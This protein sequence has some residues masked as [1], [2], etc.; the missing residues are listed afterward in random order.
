MKLLSV[1]AALVAITMAV[2][3][4]RA[5]DAAP[6]PTAVE[7]IKR[8]QL[9]RIEFPT[10]KYA[11]MIYMV[12]IAPG[13]V[14]PRHTHPGVEMTYVQDGEG[15]LLIEGQPEIVLKPGSSFTVPPVTPHS[16]KNTG[17]AAL[18]VVVTYVVE[19]DKPLATAAPLQ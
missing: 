9:Q 15:T 1:A 11:T 7:I 19:K 18:R 13:A 17:A 14:I 10:D 3:S 16:A 12:E 8:L 5:E 6:K 2:S 4:V